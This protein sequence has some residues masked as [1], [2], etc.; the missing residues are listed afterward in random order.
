MTCKTVRGVCQKCYGNNLGTGK[1]VEI[2]LAVGIIAAQAMGEAAT[3]LT[4][5]T[6]HLAGRAGTDITQGLP[7][8]EE[9]FE[10]RTP[11]A[12]AILS[13]I[14]GKVKINIDDK[15]GTKTLIITSSEE[16]N[17]KMKIE[18]GDVLNFKRS[19]RFKKGDLL[20]TKKDGTEIEAPEAVSAKVEESE[21]I[22]TIQNEREEI[23]QFELDDP[24]MVADGAEVT[25]GT[26][27]TP[28]SL[29][30]K[31]VLDISGP[32]E[33]KRYIIDNIQETYGI[34][35]IALD[36]RHVEI[37]VR[38][39]IR[40]GKISDSGD[41]EYLPGD[42]VDSLELDEANVTL[43]SQGKRPIKYVVQLLGLTTASIKTESFLS[44]ASFQE[45]VRVLTD[46]AMVG[47]VD[48][49]RGLKENVIIGRPV[50]LGGVLRSKLD[51]IKNQEAAE[52]VEIVEEVAEQTEEVVDEEIE[53]AMQTE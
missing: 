12:K 18:E 13:P 2:G 15:A 44:A 43:N 53:Q 7:R 16:K 38:Q 27:L 25:K 47:K 42:Y 49:L 17:R 24:I 14:D 1:L 31:E 22:F 48:D 6:K 9:L 10:A 35:G 28:G 30:P 23:Y 8:V 21:I 3:Q 50:P 51:E 45:Q 4:L 5:N 34:Q 32:M 39:M 29:D 52:V 46:A 33:T 19:K 37:V 26:I 41:S 36:D 11:K 20:L 40:F